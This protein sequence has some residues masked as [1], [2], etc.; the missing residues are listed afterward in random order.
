M[1]LEIKHHAANSDKQTSTQHLALPLQ[2]HLKGCTK[3]G[4]G[5]PMKRGSIPG[6]HIVLT[7]KTSILALGPTQPLIQCLPRARSLGVKRPARSAEF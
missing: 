6:K 7:C 3:L 4:D 2:T 5:K 1:G